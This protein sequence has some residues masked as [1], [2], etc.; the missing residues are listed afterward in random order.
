MTRPLF[1]TL[2]REAQRRHKWSLRH[3]AFLCDLDPATVSRTLTDKRS[4]SKDVMFTFAKF[5][6]VPVEKLFRLVPNGK[7]E[8]RMNVEEL[9]EQVDEINRVRISMQKTKQLL[10]D[11]VVVSDQHK[12][13]VDYLREQIHVDN[14]LLLAME[15]EIADTAEIAKQA[16]NETKGV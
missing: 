14:I 6:D 4:P 15:R 1:H 3:I 13:L 12:R 2:F 7:G 9:L 10:D 11:L 5:F 16:E 8:Y